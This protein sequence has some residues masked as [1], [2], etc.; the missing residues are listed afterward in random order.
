MTVAELKAILADASD[1]SDI[2]IDDEDLADDDGN[3]PELSGCSIDEDGDVILTVEWM[4]TA[5]F[6]EY[7]VITGE[8]PAEFGGFWPVV[9]DYSDCG[10][11]EV[12][13]T[14]PI[15]YFK[16]RELA[17]RCVNA[18]N[19]GD[20]WMNS[21]REISGPE[22]DDLI[23]SQVVGQRIVG[24]HVDLA[25]EHQVMVVLENGHAIGFNFIAHEEPFHILV[26]KPKQAN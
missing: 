20:F 16:D 6:C 15:A 10:C 11:G 8:H 13:L 1:D 26:V 12:H 3:I 7:K 22:A 9:A 2:F 17:Q 25:S 14:A 5:H 4:P 21:I 18:L 24:I 19:S 23:N